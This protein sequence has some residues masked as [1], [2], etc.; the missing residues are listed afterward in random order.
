MEFEAINVS[1]D[2]SDLSDLEQIQVQAIKTR[3]LGNIPMLQAYMIWF[4]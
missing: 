2:M 1:I 4:G 3:I